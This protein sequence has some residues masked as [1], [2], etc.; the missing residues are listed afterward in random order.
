MMKALRPSAAE[1]RWLAVKSRFGERVVDDAQSGGWRTSR[2][3]ARI[4]FFF[5][6]AICCGA[7]WGFFSLLFQW[8]GAFVAGGASLVVAEVLIVGYRFFHS[9][10]EEAL[11]VCGLALMAAA[12]T[13]ESADID[14]YLIAAAIG[15]AIAAVRLLDPIFF[16]G[17]AAALAWSGSRA[18]APFVTG[19]VCW[20]AAYGVW[21]ALTKHFVRPS[22]E[23]ALAILG[24]ALPLL[25][26]LWVKDFD[27]WRW[28]WNGVPSL[29]DFSAAAPL[30]LPLVGVALA[31]ILGLTYRLHA[32][33][34]ASMVCGAMLAFDLRHLTGATVEQRFLTE[35]ALLLVAAIVIERRLR[36]RTSG[37]TAAPI[38]EGSE[39]AKLIELAGSSVVA[40]RQ[41]PDPAA[42]APQLQTGGGEFGGAGASGSL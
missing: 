7:A 11:H 10:I 36:A 13:P 31:L 9:G 38:G 2:L 28:F 41:Q 32:L 3:F 14:S 30:L 15:C 23:M 1:E 17:T 20:L 6:G 22:T 33:L 12:V 19:V 27:P 40:A 42:A 39:L 26:W 16:V 24:I 34:L 25:G 29:R 4:A 5:L 21:L 37:I 18:G 35:G 8:R